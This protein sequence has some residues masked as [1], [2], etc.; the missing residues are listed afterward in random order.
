MRLSPRECLQAALV[1]LFTVK[2]RK[3]SVVAVSG[4]RDSQARERQG[5]KSNCHRSRSL[6]GVIP[7]IVAKVA[8]GVLRGLVMHYYARLC[9]MRRASRG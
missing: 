4:I 3:V 6:G 8:Y 1:L 2:P 9:R 7:A 5:F